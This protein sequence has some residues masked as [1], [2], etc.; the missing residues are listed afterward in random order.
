MNIMLKGLEIF[1][2][3]LNFEIVD[4]YVNKLVNEL[5]F[6]FGI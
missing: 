5:N 1:V 3:L 2:C 4:V 6:L